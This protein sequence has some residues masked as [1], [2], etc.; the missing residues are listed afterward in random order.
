MRMNYHC[1]V[2]LCLCL[3]LCACNVEISDAFLHLW[4]SYLNPNQIIMQLN[5]KVLLKMR[6]MQFPSSTNLTRSGYYLWCNRNVSLLCFL[7]CLLRSMLFLSSSL[8]L[9]ISSCCSFSFTLN[10]LRMW[11]FF[12]V[13]CVSMF[14]CVSN[15]ARGNW[16][17]QKIERT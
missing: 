14:V 6:L 17:D 4:H 1:D 7:S 16:C 3:C 15:Y 2:Y 13:F 11:K 8:L 5:G 12:C 10:E 9:D